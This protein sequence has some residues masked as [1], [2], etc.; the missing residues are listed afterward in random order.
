MP[1]RAS[2]AT[3]FCMKIG[4]RT[5]TTW[6]RKWKSPGKTVA[7]RVPEALASELLW[8]AR[9]MDEQGEMSGR[10]LSRYGPL[11]TTE[12][13]AALPLSICV[14]R[15]KYRATRRKESP[16]TFF[17]RPMHHGAG[18]RNAPL[19]LRHFT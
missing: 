18:I 6:A 5:G 19:R 16:P 4:G 17:P 8:L 10:D 13:R 1:V 9:E 11:R 12:A 3:L 2:F 7:I 15:S 14:Y